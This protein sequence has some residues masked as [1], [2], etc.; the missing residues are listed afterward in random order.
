MKIEKENLGLQD[1]FY[2]GCGY[3]IILGIVCTAIFYGIFDVSYW[4]YTTILDASIS[5]ISLL[6]NT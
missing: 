5:P 4:K 6:A 1:Y 3:L 2:T